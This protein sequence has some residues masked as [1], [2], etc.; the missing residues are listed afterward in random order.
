MA[1]KLF[2]DCPD[3]ITLENMEWFESVHNEK[4]EE[5]MCVCCYK[6]C[7]CKDCAVAVLSRNTFK[8]KNCPECE[9]I[10]V[11]TGCSPFICFC[12]DRTCNTCCAENRLNGG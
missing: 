5:G 12:V 2:P 1:D 10:V 8:I 11:M 3:P 4:F 7:P 9:G 6:C